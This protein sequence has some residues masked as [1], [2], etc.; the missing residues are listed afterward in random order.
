MEMLTLLLESVDVTKETS[1]P[2]SVC[3]FFLMLLL[4]YA[5]VCEL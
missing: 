4:V 2:Y 3:N 5:I 1:S